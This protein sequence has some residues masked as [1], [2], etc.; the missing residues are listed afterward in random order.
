MGQWRDTVTGTVVKEP[1]KELQLIVPA[2]AGARYQ[3]EDRRHRRRLQ[4]PFRQQAV[5][6]V[7]RPARASF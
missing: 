2:D 3:G 1:S 4:N 6:I 7:I 5:G